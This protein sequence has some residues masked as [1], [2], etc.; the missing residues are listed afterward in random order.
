MAAAPKAALIATAQPSRPGVTNWIVDSESSSTRSVSSAKRG[1]WP[2]RATLVP[3]TKA[4]SAPWV[5]A[6][7]TWSV[8]V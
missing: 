3:S 6:A 1:G 7:F 2:E 5:T 8:W 4:C